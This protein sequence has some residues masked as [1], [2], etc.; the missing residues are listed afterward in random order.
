MTVVLTRNLVTPAIQREGFLPSSHGQLYY[1]DQGPIDGVPVIMVMGLACQL[2]MWP[3]T[4]VQQML[5]EGFRVIRFDNR[6]IGL[7]DPASIGLKVSLPEVMVKARV[8]LP[9]AVNYTVYDMV[10]DT[11]AVMD[12]L[13]LI[14]AHLVGASMG[15]MICQLTAAIYPQRVASLTSIMSTTNELD[16]PLPR[17]DILMA[18]NGWGLPKG[19]DKATAV[20]RSDI[21]WGMIASPRIG[22]TRDER[23][24][25]MADNFDRSYRPAGVLRQTQA[26]AATGGFR[27]LLG[28]V[29]CPT[30]V[31]HGAVDP[32]VN[33]RCGSDT[34]KHIP[35]AKLH[36]YKGMAHDFP[37]SLVP[38][39]GE[40]ITLNIA[41]ALPR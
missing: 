33:V 35:G 16:L 39:M 17:R 2:T 5:G 32:L 40:K 13:G 9:V 34:A 14:N 10:K 25:K 26:I 19:H 37:P 22:E 6:D 29:R 20:K 36:V 21:F 30:Q 31:L 11:I 38:D 8:G 24:Q 23:L 28:R 3:E 15:G 18:L 41:E 27:R 4:L 12:G 7:S 1:L